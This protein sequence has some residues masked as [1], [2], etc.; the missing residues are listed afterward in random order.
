M[1]M[2]CMGQV[3]H[4]AILIAGAQ[5]PRVSCPKRAAGRAHAGVADQAQYIEAFTKVQT[6]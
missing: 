5:S 3:G 6:H 4:L 1:V 2:C